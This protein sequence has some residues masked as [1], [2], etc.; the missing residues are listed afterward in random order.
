MMI[1]K[2]AMMILLLVLGIAA[3]QTLAQ[4]Q[5]PPNPPPSGLT[6]QAIAR[7]IQ[8]SPEMTEGQT[9]ELAGAVVG[10]QRGKT[11]LELKTGNFLKMKHGETKELVWS[12]SLDTYEGQK[13][14]SFP[15][16]YFTRSALLYGQVGYSSSGQ[17]YVTDSSIVYQT[18]KGK[19][20]Y[21]CS[22]S[23]DVL[24]EEGGREGDTFSLYDAQGNRYRFGTAKFSSPFM[25]FFQTAIA[26]FPGAYNQVLQ[27]AAASKVATVNQP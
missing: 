17:I 3:V 5:T 26:D 24:K 21:S 10:M 1:A 20:V 14:I 6:G 2:A 25:K 16:A 13:A 15:A 11:T 9:P 18:D 7:K 27:L 22:R 12:A 19:V 4:N 8:E 23:A